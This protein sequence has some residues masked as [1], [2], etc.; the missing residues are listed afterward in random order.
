MKY[1]CP[2]RS[3]NVQINLLQQV[4]C[5]RIGCICKRA[6]S[7]RFNT[8]VIFNIFHYEARLNLYCLEI[9]LLLHCIKKLLNTIKYRQG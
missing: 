8:A 4:Q 3:Y 6:Y 7:T 1:L 5:L 9:L 2:E